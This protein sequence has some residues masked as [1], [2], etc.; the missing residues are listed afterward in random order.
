MKILLGI[1]NGTKFLKFDM[2]EANFKWFV[3][4]KVNI[5]KNCIDRHLARK[6]VIKPP[7]F[8]NQIIQA[9]K[10]NILLTMNYMP[11]S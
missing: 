11:S 8:L 1:K 5:T 3:N 7:L 10:H 9:K 6:E 2:Q 4:A